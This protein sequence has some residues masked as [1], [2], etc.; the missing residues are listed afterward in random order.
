MNRTQITFRPTILMVCLAA[1]CGGAAMAQPAKP[2]PQPD[3][4]YDLGG[5]LS[6]GVQWLQRERLRGT[7]FHRPNVGTLRPVYLQ[8][9][10]SPVA[11]SS[12]AVTLR[13]QHFISILVESQ[14]EICF[15]L[16]SARTE[17][18]C[19]FSS[20]AVFGPQ[21]ETI[22]ADQV[23]AGK[24]R[25]V[26]VAVTTPGRYILVVNPGIASRNVARVSVSGLPWA[27]EGTRK[28]DYLGT[29]LEYHF[30]G[31]LKQAGLNL[32]MLDFESLTQEIVTNEGL[33]KWKDKVAAWANHAQRYK[34]RLMPAI[35]LGGTQYEVDAWGDSP[36]GLYVE[37]ASDREHSQAGTPL[38]PCPLSRLYWERIVLR[39]ARE[40]ARLSL[41]NPYVVGIGIDPE[42]YMCHAYGHY[43]SSG[44]CYCDHCLGGF[45]RQKNLDAAVLG[46]LAGQGPPRLAPPPE[47]DAPVRQVPGRRDGGAGRLAA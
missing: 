19:S 28:Q 30:L 36:K 32:V 23:E 21:G 38:A 45:L 31:E 5:R 41:K 7:L 43:Q 2:A 18:P 25:V 46:G 42:M 20:Y 11:G 37:D 9:I 14:K 16:K 29:P 10:G 6:P 17:E 24:G 12:A 3:A 1:A 22:A 13:G 44:T 27:L 47:A 34:I 40:L 39:R 15:E 4:V 26:R 35:D 8:A 33:K